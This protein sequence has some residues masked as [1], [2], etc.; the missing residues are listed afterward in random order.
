[1]VE[2]EFTLAIKRRLDALDLDIR[3]VIL[4][5][6]VRKDYLSVYGY[7]HNNAP[8]LNSA[9]GVFIDGFIAPSYNTPSSVPLLFGL[10]LNG[11]K[12]NYA[13]SVVRLAN[14]AGFET[15]WISNQGTRNAAF[16]TRS[17]L[18][19]N[20]ALHTE[21]IGSKTMEI[22]DDFDLFD[23]FDRALDDRVDK[24][25]IIFLHMYGSHNDP[26]GRLHGFSNR[27]NLPYGD[28]FNCYLATIE[29]LDIFIKTLID[30]MNTRQKSWAL[31]YLS[32]HGLLHS[33]EKTS[34][35]FKHTGTAKQSYEV[36]FFALDCNDK[37][38]IIIKRQV[39]GLKFFD[40]FSVWIGYDTDASD[41]NYTM[42]DFPQS[43]NIKTPKGD[44]AKLYDDP[45]L[46]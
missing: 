46:Y 42:R 33:G 23:Y 41:P 6:S 13:N 3:V 22:R 4:G 24:P 18:F 30:K 36:P 12:T 38:H 19:A 40:F 32:D 45:A 31:L 2:G 44:Y 25:K 16:D 8:F 17:S 29:K 7:P 20:Q 14:N 1:M 9:N 15:Y 10:N 21:Y 39:S 27:Y 11:G 28:S 34:V 35:K 37:E 43:V 26:C 5:E